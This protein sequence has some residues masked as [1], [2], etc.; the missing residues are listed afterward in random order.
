MACIRV[1][2][3]LVTAALGCASF[4]TVGLYCNHAD[5]SP[6]HAPFLLGLTN[7][8]GALPGIIGA[9]PAATFMAACSSSRTPGSPALHLAGGMRVIGRRDGGRM[10]VVCYVHV[11]G[12]A[13][14]E[15]RPAASRCG[16][17]GCAQGG[18]GSQWTPSRQCC[19]KNPKGV[20]DTL[21]AGVAVTGALLDATGSWN[22]ALFAPS[23]AL[24][25]TGIAVFA[26]LGSSDLQDFDAHDEPFWCARAPRQPPSMECAV[27]CQ[28]LSW[29]AHVPWTCQ[30][31]A[32]VPAGFLNAGRLFRED[33]RC[34]NKITL[35]ACRFEERLAP[36]ARPLAGLGRRLGSLG[37]QG[38]T[39]ASMAGRLL[40]NASKDKRL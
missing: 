34:A 15:R 28:P 33:T 26:A 7:T 20:R 19:R 27:R 21:R 5:L 2:A 36:V 39:L 14:R 24:F 4:S 9:G 40:P 25:V 29:S 16:G 30:R 8:T 3:A 11:R 38:L 17:V 35:L 6:R 18:T 13:C 23:I 22:Y 1:G 32:A 10:V 31:N 12:S 37:K